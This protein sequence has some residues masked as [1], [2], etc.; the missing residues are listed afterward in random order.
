MEGAG[1]IVGEYVES[2]L[3]SIV[4]LQ[5]MEQHDKR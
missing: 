3:K 2:K 4:V 5:H 1:D